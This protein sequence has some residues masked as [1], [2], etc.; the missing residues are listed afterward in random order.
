MS[1]ASHS[2]QSYCDNWQFIM[3]LGVREAVKSGREREE[4]RVSRGQLPVSY[5]I[6]A[7]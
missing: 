4:L 6:S 2:Y 1:K 7:V 5:G 3:G